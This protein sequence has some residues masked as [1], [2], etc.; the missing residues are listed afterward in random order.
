MHEQLYGGGSLFG[1]SGN[2][3][4]LNAA[5]R[6]RFIKSAESLPP[7][8][9]LLCL[10][11]A[12][13]GARISEAL[14]LTPAAIDIESGLAGIQTL[15]RR[16][17]G[18]IR[19]VPL[20]PDLL[21]DLD[22][23]FHIRDAQRDPELANERLWRFSRTT[24]WRLVKEIMA[25]ANIFG[26]QAS[27]K[28]LRHGFG[29]N[30]IA[31]GV[32]LTLLQKWMGHASLRTTAIYIDVVGPDERAFAARMWLGVVPIGREASNI[33]GEAPILQRPEPPINLC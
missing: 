20:P 3:K 8:D 28:G 18:V 9:R 32:P 16:K 12:F 31:S 19:Q 13:S 6:R 4:Y 7:A 27:P 14:A 10:V 26:M 1:P 22:Q 21:S 30:A 23:H 11:L 17:R 5:E 29:V 15:K 24:A 33:M 2:R 25:A